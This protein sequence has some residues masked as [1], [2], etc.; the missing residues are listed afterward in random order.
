MGFSLRT[1]TVQLQSVEDDK[2][3]LFK[4]VPQASRVLTKTHSTLCSGLSFMQNRLILVTQ[5]KKLG[6]NATS[7][8]GSVEELWQ[9]FFA[10][11][12]DWWDNRKN[13]KNPKYPNFKH[14]DAGKALWVEGR[15]NLPWVKSQMAILDT[16]MGSL[17]DQ[18]TRMDAS[19]MAADKFLPF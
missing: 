5:G 7:N 4:W 2:V 11:P 17:Y 19:L 9:A 18:D 16:P 14:K 12:V 3:A 1:Y 10:N 8:V 13:K 6:N 15:Y